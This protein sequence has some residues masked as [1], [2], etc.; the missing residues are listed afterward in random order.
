M[1]VG[2]T[3]QR[4]RSQADGR[5]FVTVTDATG[6]R[7]SLRV[8][9]DKV[10]VAYPTQMLKSSDSPRGHVIR[11]LSQPESPIRPCWRVARLERGRLE[12]RLRRMRW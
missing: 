9:I 3:H 10:C 1:P 2:R 7:V 8:F 4:T 12:F 5:I 6:R 11:L